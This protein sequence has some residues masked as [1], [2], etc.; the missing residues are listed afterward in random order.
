MD[1]D[2]FNLIFLCD[3]NSWKQDK[4]DDIIKTNYNF[5]QFYIST[6]KLWFSTIKVKSIKLIVNSNGNS[7]QNG[8]YI[9][10]TGY[11][12]V[13]DKYFRK[14]WCIDLLLKYNFLAFYY[15]VLT[16][17]CYFVFCIVILLNCL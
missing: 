3:D 1:T 12:M 9:I 6:D 10:M 8:Y 15:K 5:F 2:S 11:C 17:F 4:V 16:L 13:S 14:P 7:L